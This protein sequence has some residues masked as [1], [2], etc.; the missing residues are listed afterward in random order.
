MRMAALLSASAREEMRALQNAVIVSL[1]AP[2][3]SHHALNVSESVTRWYRKKFAPDDLPYSERDDVWFRY[4]DPDHVRS[5][6]RF[7]LGHLPAC[8]ATVES[9]A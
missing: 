7:V 5:W 3:S 6:S 4:A 8:V 9:W 2:P 1:T